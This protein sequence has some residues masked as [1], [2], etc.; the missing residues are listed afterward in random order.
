MRQLAGK[1]SCEFGILDVVD[2][3]EEKIDWQDVRLRIRQAAVDRGIEFRLILDFLGLNVLQDD[4]LERKEKLPK[5]KTAVAVAAFMGVSASWILT[6]EEPRER[7]S[8]RISQS[9]S[10]TTD[11]TVVQGN[12]AGTIVING[13]EPLSGQKKELMR[14]F[15]ALS[16]RNQTRLLN[17]AYE[18]EDMDRAN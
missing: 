9:I 12:T 11:S 14:I 13:P 10:D 6:G 17:F 5:V 3:Q 18:V 7:G 4:Y 2:E 1:T 16:I 15:D 8:T